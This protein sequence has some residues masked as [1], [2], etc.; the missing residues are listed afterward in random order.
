MAAAIERPAA[1]PT[2]VT[3]NLV[4]APAATTSLPATTL[5]PALRWIASWLDEP[6]VLLPDVPDLEATAA[7]LAPLAAAARAELAPADAAEVI[8]FLKAFADRHRLDLPDVHALEL[9]AETL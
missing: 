9:D 4:P 1:R 8:V 3:L 7:A 5:P 2:T 6:T